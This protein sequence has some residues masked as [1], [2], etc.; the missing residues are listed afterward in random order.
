MSYDEMRPVL[1]DIAPTPVYGLTSYGIDKGDGI[2]GGM[3]GGCVISHVDQGYA[4]ADM[5]MQYFHGTPVH[6]VPF[7]TESPNTNMIDFQ[8]LK[9]F[10][11]SSDRLP[12]DTVVLN[13]SYTFWEQYW[14]TV[15]LGILV[16]LIE[17][18]I[19]FFLIFNTLRRRRTED[20]LRENEKKFRSYIENAPDG[21][22]IIN[23]KDEILDV[24]ESACK[25]TGY[26]RAE[27]LSLSLD[28]LIR[29]EYRERKNTFLI[30]LREKG[31]GGDELGFKTRAG[32]KKFFGIDAVKL[33]EDRF[34]AFAKDITVRKE[35]EETKEKL[36]NQLFHSQKMDAVGQLAG[37]VAHDFNNILSG[38]MGA[39]QILQ[40]PKRKND[41]ETRLY[42]DMIM[43]AC[44][45]AADLNS[46][47]LAFS[48]KGKV[49]ST[50]I[51]MNDSID[52][53]LAIITHTIDKKIEIKIE[54]EAK[55]TLVI[56]DAAALEKSLLNLCINASH[57]MPEGGDLVIA[58]RNVRLNEHYCQHSP[59]EIEAGDYI[60][61][62]VR[63]SGT[64]IAVE[65]MEKIFEP[66]FTTKEEGRGTGLGLAAVYGT[67]QDHQGAISVYSEVGEGTAFHLLIPCS[68]S[69]ELPEEQIENV[70]S[71][72]GIVL[73]VDDEE[74]IRITGK[75]T[76]EEM[77]YQVIL[78]ENGVEA[79][80]L[81]REKH[82]QIDLVL[83]DMIMP[84][85]NGSE[86]FRL[87]KEIDDQCRVVLSS[88]FTKYE[89][90]KELKKM[91]LSGFI[92]KPYTMKELLKLMSELMDK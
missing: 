9:R 73:L 51:D 82:G 6:E 84:R 55:N 52:D 68:E 37:G 8:Q 76:L 19:I 85:M 17:S 30:E 66:F 77:G 63:D 31:R 22:F 4:A 14:K 56:G 5:V 15:I 1:S 2:N 54:K 33:S 39:A 72:T 89:S 49:S 11:F 83:M 20:K 36:E 46:K 27:L 34:L 91:G 80:D 62:E 21:I 79:V 75:Y 92:Q 69:H 10:G 35:A 64:G 25:D 7:T 3:I 50:V 26:S 42:L 28:E 81:F 48:R 71:G 59:F 38:I 70:I 12:E 78:A 47:L 24:N 87:M 32:E 58:T 45:R 16:I 61:I 13:R 57:A 44:Q 67:V 86:A 60:D 74:F 43:S 40:L 90:L 65:N 88:G 53:A 29:D 18:V 23:E 41:K